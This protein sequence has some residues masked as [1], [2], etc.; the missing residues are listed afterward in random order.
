M[1]RDLQV[2]KD[3]SS[4]GCF[5]FFQRF[6]VAFSF[7]SPKKPISGF[8]EDYVFLASSTEM[9][10]SPEKGGRRVSVDLGYWNMVLV[11]EGK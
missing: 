8:N 3:F 6:A 10:R 4:Y 9:N 5:F 7:S 1:K 2:R 11:E